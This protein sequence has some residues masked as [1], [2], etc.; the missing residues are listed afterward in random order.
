MSP[1]NGGVSVLEVLPDSPAHKAGIKKGDTIE[2]IDG[3]Q[4]KDVNGLREVLN[5]LEAGKKK[6]PPASSAAT[7]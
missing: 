7:N 6:S 3:K 5:K 2:Q 4:I 1:N